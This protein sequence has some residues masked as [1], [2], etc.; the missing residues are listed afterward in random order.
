MCFY[1][2]LTIS[3]EGPAC[4]ASIKGWKGFLL[5]A[6]ESVPPHLFR[7]TELPGLV[8]AAF[9]VLDGVIRP[10]VHQTCQKALEETVE[11]EV[12]RCKSQGVDAGSGSAA[13]F[14]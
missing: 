13:S 4:L 10:V 9:Q 5:L 8:Q 11:E 3:K 1:C 12:M 2:I 7:P 14:L 6:H